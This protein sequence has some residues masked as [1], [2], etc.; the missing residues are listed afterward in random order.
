MAIFLQRIVVSLKISHKSTLQLLNFETLMTR[1][2]DIVKFFV[3]IL[4]DGWL[5]KKTVKHYSLSLKIRSNNL[6]TILL[7]AIRQIEENLYCNTTS[8]T[9]VG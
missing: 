2:L 7:V 3:G 4:H 5:K 1:E 6:G 9:F 8:E